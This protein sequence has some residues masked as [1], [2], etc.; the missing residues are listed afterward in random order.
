MMARSCFVVIHHLVDVS[1][2]SLQIKLSVKSPLLVSKNKVMTKVIPVHFQPGVRVHT[3]VQR[4]QLSVFS[5][6]RPV[7][8]MNI[9]NFMAIYPIIVAW[10]MWSEQN[11]RLPTS[12]YP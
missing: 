5:A 8:T 4:N 9:D 11:W 1:F 12:C 10:L 6:V 7:G 2:C 3:E